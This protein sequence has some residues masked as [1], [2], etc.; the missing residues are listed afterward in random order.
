VNIAIL[1]CGRKHFPRRLGGLYVTS[2]VPFLRRLIVANWIPIQ[3]TASPILWPRS[4][5]A[6]ALTPLSEQIWCLA[7]LQIWLESYSPATSSETW[8]SARLPISPRDSLVCAD[9]PRED[10]RALFSVVYNRASGNNSK[11]AAL[12][13]LPSNAALCCVSG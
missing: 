12:F 9:V 3:S 13:Q 10:E 11:D 6:Q 7:Y 5:G 1:L 4:D 2:P 8:L